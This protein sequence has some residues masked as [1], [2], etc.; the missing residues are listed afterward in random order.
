M[1]N[2]KKR[3]V[4]LDIFSFLCVVCT[5]YFLNSGFY[6]ELVVGKKMALMCII[7]SF[8]IIC[9]P[10]FIT[11]TGYLMYKKDLSKK[12]YYGIIKTLA[13]YFLCSIIYS[14]FDKYYLK[15]QMNINIF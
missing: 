12:Y 9:V 3:E 7:R 5:H 14:I 13:I 10:M 4:S 8:F 2:F 11:L 6:D 15:N 1:E